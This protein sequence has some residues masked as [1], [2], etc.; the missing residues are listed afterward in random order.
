MAD[1]DKVGTFVIVMMENRSFDHMLG[2]L[3]L[4]DPKM[5]ID[6][7]VAPAGS[8]VDYHKPGAELLNDA[9]VN[10]SSVDGELHYPFHMQDNPLTTDLPHDRHHV[11]QQL[12]KQIA[13]GRYSMDGFVDAYYNLTPTR[14]E[15]VDP[16]GFFTAAEVPMM[17]FFAR[18]FAVCDRWFA[19]LPADTHPNRLMSLSGETLIDRTSGLLPDEQPLLLDWLEKNKIEWR[20]YSDDL[21]FFALFPRLWP[22]ILLNRN[23]FRKFS[24]LTADVLAAETEP[25]PK[26]VIIEPSYVDSPIHPDHEPNDDHPPLP[27]GFGEDFLRQV[28]QA[29]MPPKNQAVWKQMVMV[30]LYDEHGGFYDH[31]SPLFPVTQSCGPGNEPFAST[32]VRVPAFVVSPFVSPGQIYSRNLDHTSVLEFLAEWL[33]P[34]TPYSDAV[35]NRLRQPGFDTE[36]GRGRLADILDLLQKPRSVPP[37]EPTGIIQGARVS[38]GK[39]IARTPNEMAFEEAVRGMIAKYPKEVAQNYPALHHWEQNR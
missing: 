4:T 28:Y 12:G 39:K 35:M 9:Y 23:R 3:S 33:R 37:N 10:V 5:K 24:S 38:Y 20:V 18:E 1:L 17:D 25:F 30:V 29:L 13:P 6:G 19:S 36:P 21:S 16:M 22:E 7:L 15:L 27:V 11:E 8:N 2:Y 26:V 14:M 32:G 34:G 31:V